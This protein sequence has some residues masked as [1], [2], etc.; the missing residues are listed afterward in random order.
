MEPRHDSLGERIARF[1]RS[2]AVGIVATVIDYIV[3]ELAARVFHVDPSLAKIPALACGTLTQFVGSR[4]FAFRAQQGH[5]GRQLKWFAFA[6]FCAFWITVIVFRVMVR[7]MRIPMEIA[8]MVSGFIVYFG[9][10]YPIWKRVFTVQSDV[11]VSAET[12]P[13]SLAP[14]NRAA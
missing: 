10:S 7:W 12:A 2:S 14:E 3:L 5:L 11:A 4:Y 1:L 9:F 8:N 6:E 13:A